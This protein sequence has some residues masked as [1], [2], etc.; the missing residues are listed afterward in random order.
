MF[1]QTKS[2][3]ANT[4]YIPGLVEFLRD[5]FFELCQFRPTVLCIVPTMQW[6]RLISKTYNISLKMLFSIPILRS[7]K[8]ISL[9]CSSPAMSSKAVLYTYGH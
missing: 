2:R 4:T 5:L 9:L 1:A 7:Y 8:V 3:V 6:R